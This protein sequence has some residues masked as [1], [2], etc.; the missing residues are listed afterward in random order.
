MDKQYKDTDLCSYPSPTWGHH[1][2]R[3]RVCWVEMPGKWVLG[4]HVVMIRLECPH[5]HT[6]TS[7]WRAAAPEDRQELGVGWGLAGRSLGGRAAGMLRNS[8]RG[9][10]VILEKGGNIGTV[11]S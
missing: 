10:S 5:L 6:H 2:G 3:T 9:R 8:G 1:A 7:C 11:L 4:G